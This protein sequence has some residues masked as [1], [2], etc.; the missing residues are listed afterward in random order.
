MRKQIYFTDEEITE[1]M[2]IVPQFKDLH[3]DYWEEDG[4]KREPEVVNNII[5]KIVGSQTNYKASS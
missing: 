1:L 5:K 2:W 3:K 4:I